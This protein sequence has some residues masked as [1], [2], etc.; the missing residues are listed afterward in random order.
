MYICLWIVHRTSHVC[1]HLA[2]PAHG[3]V[4]VR[5]RLAGAVRL[6]DHGLHDATSRVDEP[7]VYL[8]QSQ[9][10][11]LGQLLLLLLR[12]IWMLKLTEK[13]VYKLKELM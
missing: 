8:R 5:M 11:L 12:R 6:V 3:I 10:R 1:R 4:A 2:I 9:T 7:V 13:S